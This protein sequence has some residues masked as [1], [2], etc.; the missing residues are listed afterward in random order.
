MLNICSLFQKFFGFI[1][2][3]NKRSYRT[4]AVILSG[5]V[6]VS[7]ICLCAKDFGG[8]GKNLV[9]AGEK[10]V[11]TTEEE[12]EKNDTDANALLQNSLF[13]YTEVQENN[14]LKSNMYYDTSIVDNDKDVLFD[15]MVATIAPIGRE[16]LGAIYTQ[17]EKKASVQGKEN[18]L[19]CS[20]E[21]MSAA[22]SN[23]QQPETTEPVT[24][25]VQPET[26]QPETVQPETTQPETTQ[27]ETT[28]PETTQPETTQPETEA[29]A[30][31]KSVN[32][33]VTDSDYYWLTRIVE[34]EAGNQ[35]EIGKILVANVIINRVKSSMFPNDIKSVIFQNNGRTYQ[36]EP[37]KNGRIY[38]MNPTQNTISC[39]DRAL[40][41]EDYSCGALYF[42]MKTSSKSW[43]NTSLTLLFVHGDHY[44][45]TN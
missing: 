11:I 35:D 39:V 45:Y 26:T 12:T 44:F 19:V 20:N 21:E 27:P 29:V 14:S 22:D 36:F 30:L 18:E 10:A 16:I 13:G 3:I 38:D 1:K 6:I 2:N 24:E 17:A 15:R 25:A 41:G 5:A 4:S 23:A 40:N 37:V 8:S 43:F 31:Y 7:V 9:T 28:Q 32:I 34:A 42:T 33:D